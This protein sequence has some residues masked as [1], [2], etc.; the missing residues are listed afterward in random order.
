MATVVFFTPHQDDETAAMGPAVRDHLNAGHDVHVCLLTDGG[1]SVV[2]STL[3]MDEATFIAARDDELARAT[4]QVGVR[5]ANLHIP[6]GRAPDGE[7]TVAAATALMQEFLADH[8]GAWCKAYSGL[9]ATGRHPDHVASGQAAQALYDAGTI[10]NLRLYVEPW[11][12]AGFRS[13][14]PSVTVN[15]ETVSDNTA[16]LRGYTEYQRQDH[17]AGM[18]GIGYLSVGPDFL[19]PPTSY[20]HVPVV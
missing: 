9:P 8:P 2:R 14:N 15:A 11:L 6:A 13:A 4:R 10:T 5:A 1:A 17:V 19:T 18:Y 3:G 20:Y 12:V 7:L 16:V